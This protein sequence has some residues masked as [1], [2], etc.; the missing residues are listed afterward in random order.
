[1]PAKRCAIE[2]FNEKYIVNEE[3]GCW[4]WTARLDQSGYG[5]L[6]YDGGM[7]GA[8]RF[9]YKTYVGEIPEGIYV[10]HTCDNPKCVNPSHLFLG[11]QQDNMDDMYNKGRATRMSCPSY[12]MYKFG[13][14]RC[15]GC[16]AAYEKQRD[17]YKERVGA[18]V[19]KERE[20]VKYLKYRDKKLEYARQYRE[21][22][23]LKKV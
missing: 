13:N 4:E 18:D 16:V 9:S 1:M 15:D 23:K 12:V 14:C 5:L 10:C 8:H 17:D 6:C 2:R 21:K 19:I 3:N 7:K 22:M 11:T 20:R